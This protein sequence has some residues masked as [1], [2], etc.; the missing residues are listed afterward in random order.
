MKSAKKSRTTIFL[1]VAKTAGT[2]LNQVLGREYA[3]ILSFYIPKESESHFEDFKNRLKNE[4]AAL[5]RG[6]FE[7]GWHYFLSRPFTYFTILRDPVERVISE[8]FYIL[9]SP[10][11]PLFSHVAKKNVSLVDFVKKWNA[12]NLQTK[13]ISG[14]T[15]AKNSGVSQD[16]EVN[17]DNMLKMAKENLNKHFAVVGLTERFDE[18]LILFKRE[19]GWDWPFYIRDNVTKDKVA[20]EDIPSS[21]ID[22]IK[23]YNRLDIELYEYAKKCFTEQIDSQ[24]QSFYDEVE[25]FKELN[26]IHVDKIIR[27]KNKP[28]KFLNLKRKIKRLVRYLWT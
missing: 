7:F 23:E 12:P 2:T 5:I 20:G 11:H 6:H 13:K 9:R 8:Y 27:N 21:T 17:A 28:V 19:F 15:F 3:D 1:H 25:K 22:I 24:G 10:G 18:T 26:K 4:N 16:V 14:T